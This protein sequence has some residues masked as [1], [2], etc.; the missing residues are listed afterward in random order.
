MC[1]AGSRPRRGRRRAVLLPAALALALLAGAGCSGSKPAAP[2]HH[3]IFSPN[4]EPLSGGPLGFPKCPAALGGWFDRLDRAH[5]G[6]IDRATFL[7]DAERQF[8]VM[9]LNHDGIL[10]PEVLL[11]YREPY[12]TG[13]VAERGPAPQGADSDKAGHPGHMRKPG[14]G[15]AVAGTADI[16]RDVP[17]PVM[18]AD[19]SLRLRV[20]EPEFLAHAARV[21]DSLDADRDGRLSRPEVAQWCG[22][23]APTEEKSG[24]GVLDIF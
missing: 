21:F 12:A 10:T 19:T 24:G 15:R 9:D 7:A 3:A 23:I 1:D 17:D 8:K 2:V 22:V 13:V 5:Q 4:G 14:S 20:T 16:S 6:T 18:S 11:R